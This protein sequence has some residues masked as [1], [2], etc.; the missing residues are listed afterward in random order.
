MLNNITP[1]ILTYN[2]APNIERSLQKLTWAS[3]IVIVDSYSTDN[4][5]DIV[6][7]FPQVEIFQR[8]FDDHTSQWNHGL[9]QVKTDWALSLDADYVLTDALIREL[10]NLS[11]SSEI[12]GYFA[13][14]QYC[15]FGRPLKGTILPPRQLLFKVACSTYVQD[16]HTQLLKV[17]GQSAQLKETVLHDD[18]KSLSRWLWAQNR[19]MDIEAKKLLSTPTAEL[20]LADKLRKQKVIAPFAILIYCLILKKGV[21][22]GWHG[23]YYALQRMFA[24]ILLSL[25]LIEI[26][27]LKN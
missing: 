16:G 13:S 3:R 8:S 11:V 24:E 2:E 1:V 10:A 27:P 18:R 14:F 9:V 25:K 19:Y 6:T 4:T 7:A 12:D 17:Q 15:V 5:V 26:E 22:D 20:T 23:W 21:L